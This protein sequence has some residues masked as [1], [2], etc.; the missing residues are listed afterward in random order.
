[1]VLAGRGQ[2]IG[3]R[4]LRLHQIA[5]Q[6]RRRDPVGGV[7]TEQSIAADRGSQI[8]EMG[9]GVYRHPIDGLVE[10]IVVYAD[11]LARA[12]DV[13]HSGQGIQESTHNLSGEVSV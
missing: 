6:R 10:P 3:A 13:Q 4:G 9:D 2:R 12:A 1:M 7:Q 8:P 11:V 5:K